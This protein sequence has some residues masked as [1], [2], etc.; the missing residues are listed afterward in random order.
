MKAWQVSR[1]GEPEDVP[2]LASERHPAQ[3]RPGWHRWQTP[4]GNVYVQEPWRYPA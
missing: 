3:A 2:E 4:S 1:P